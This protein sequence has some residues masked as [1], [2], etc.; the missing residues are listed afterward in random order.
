M[1]ASRLATSLIVAGCCLSLAGCGFIFESRTERAMRNTPNFK[2][3]YADGCSTANAQGTNYGRTM[4]RDDNLYRSDKAYRAGWAAGVSA[5]RSNL[6][7]QPGV[8][9][10]PIP[11]VSPGR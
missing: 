7:S 5:C 3:G 8:P 2:S 4:T 9:G 6:A 11:D 1:S 10:N